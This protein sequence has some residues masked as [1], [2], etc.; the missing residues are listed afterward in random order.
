MLDIM[1]PI[2][3]PTDPPPPRPTSV[4]LGNRP[5]RLAGIV[6]AASTPVTGMLTYAF[7][8]IMFGESRLEGP[9]GLTMPGA[10]TLGVPAILGALLVLWSFLTS[11]TP[12]R[13]TMA[14]LSASVSVAMLGTGLWS[15]L[16][17]SG[18]A[19]IGG[20]LLILASLP[21]GVVG[22]MLLFTKPTPG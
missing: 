12:G 5:L 18:D 19:S 9:D 14:A 4:G 21:L 13:R 22:L 7:V 1:E 10:V 20:G 3:A 15:T 2:P 17:A 6:L 11:W 8:A 16:S